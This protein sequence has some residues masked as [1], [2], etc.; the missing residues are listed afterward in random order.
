M[1][2]AGNN[3]RYGNQQFGG[4]G[5]N[6]RKFDDSNEHDFKRQRTNSEQHLIIEDELETTI[7]RLGEIDPKSP[8]TE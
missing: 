8:V 5:F 6:K 7:Y 4:G 3:S 2:Y 1:S